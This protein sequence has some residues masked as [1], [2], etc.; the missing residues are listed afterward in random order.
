MQ[1]NYNQNWNYKEITLFPYKEFKQRCKLL[2][3]MYFDN[4]SFDFISDSHYYC[5]EGS[6]YFTIL[7]KE[8]FNELYTITQNDCAGDLYFSVYCGDYNMNYKKE[9]EYHFQSLT[10]AINFIIS[11]I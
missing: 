3:D 6:H 2:F 10:N 7:D 11:R 1:A 4:E 5:G 9:N 8:S